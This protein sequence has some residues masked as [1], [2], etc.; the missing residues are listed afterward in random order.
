MGDIIISN[1]VINL[2]P[3]KEQVLKSCLRI[4]KPGGELYFSDVYANRRIPT[5]LRNDEVLWGECLSGALYWNDFQNLAKATGFQD[6]RLLEDS[7]ITVE[8]AAV[9]KT[10]ELEG[11][12]P[13]CEDYGQAVIY[14]GTIP[15]FRSGW[16][17]DN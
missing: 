3:D 16:A 15:M 14:K 4:L 8:N 2:C 7:V 17:L 13:H 5:S 9:Q 10:I 11:L 12:E 1:C 6:P